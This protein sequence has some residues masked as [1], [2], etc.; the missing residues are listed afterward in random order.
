MYKL[1]HTGVAWASSVR[2][3]D[4]GAQVASQRNFIIQPLGLPQGDSKTH[5]YCMH[6]FGQTLSATWCF[7][8]AA[9]VWEAVTN[10]PTLMVTR[11]ARCV[12]CMY[13]SDQT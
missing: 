8:K 10:T 2:M 5:S 7:F 3:Y 4:L 11:N 9:C 1:V 6:R 12:V 13:C